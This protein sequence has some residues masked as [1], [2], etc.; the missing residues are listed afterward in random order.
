[1]RSIDLAVVNWTFSVVYR[2]MNFR[3]LIVPIRPSKE[4]ELKG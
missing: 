1:M 2:W 4:D 3:N